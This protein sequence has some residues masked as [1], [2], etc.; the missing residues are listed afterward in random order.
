MKLKGLVAFSCRA[1]G[2]QAP[3]TFWA[4]STQIGPTSGCLEPQGIVDSISG[5]CLNCDKLVRLR[6][7]P[8]SFGLAGFVASTPPKTCKVIAPR[9]FALLRSTRLLLGSRYT[10]HVHIRL[11]FA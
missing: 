6:R 8:A 10:R 4:E 2:F 3:T 7:L 11:V 1:V 5:P 9:L